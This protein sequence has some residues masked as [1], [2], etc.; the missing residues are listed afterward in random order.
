L[1]EV[2]KI[3]RASS[4]TYL[5]TKK[6]RLVPATNQWLRDEPRDEYSMLALNSMNMCGSINLT[7]VKQ[8]NGE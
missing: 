5:T 8:E 7:L 6:Y 2:N 4:A 3:R 1:I